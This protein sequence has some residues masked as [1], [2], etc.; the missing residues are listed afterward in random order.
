MT[1]GGRGAGRR[2]GGGRRPATQRPA[3][4]NGTARRQ[5]S[6]PRLCSARGLRRQLQ[7]PCQTGGVT[8]NDRTASGHETT[9][10]D[11]GTRSTADVDAGCHGGRLAVTGTLPNAWERDARRGR[12]PQGCRRRCGARQGP[13]RRR[14]VWHGGCRRASR[15]PSK[16]G[17]IAAGVGDGCGAERDRPGRRCRAGERA[18]CER[19]SPCGACPA[20]RAA[21]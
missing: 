11:G 14:Q 16:G 8:A 4:R 15:V 3:I 5:A 10:D 19:T 17:A 1:G 6:S 12:R 2:P 21:A 20:G 7:P 9:R 18:G 13:H